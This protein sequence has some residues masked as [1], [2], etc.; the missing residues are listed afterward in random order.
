MCGGNGSHSGANSTEIQEYSDIVLPAE[1]IEP[2]PSRTTGHP[3]GTFW[4]RPGT[5]TGGAVT[6]IVTMS[7]AWVEP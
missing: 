3:E 6:V 2:L 1:A 5:A 7:V 4:S